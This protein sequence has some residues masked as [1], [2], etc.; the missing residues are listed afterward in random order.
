MSP[1]QTACF[2]LPYHSGVNWQCKKRTEQRTFLPLVSI[3]KKKARS[4]KIRKSRHKLVH[5]IFAVVAAAAAGTSTNWSYTQA[6]P[7]YALFLQSNHPPNSSI[8]FDS[9]RQT[10]WHGTW[11]RGHSSQV[12][13][14][15]GE[16]GGGMARDHWPE[17]PCPLINKR[18]SGQLEQW[19]CLWCYQNLLNWSPVV[20]M[21]DGGEGEQKTEHSRNIKQ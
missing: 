13:F 11:T 8:H 6:K 15:R 14:S 1:K 10:L 7:H 2:L 20:I 16:E 12:F 19:Q 3:Q 9:D 4:R 5:D 21:N 17:Q 18:D